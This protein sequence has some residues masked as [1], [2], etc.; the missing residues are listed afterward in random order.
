[1]T[2][3][4]SLIRQSLL[5]CAILQVGVLCGQALGQS[6]TL[7]ELTF[8]N[9]GAP[10][11]QAAFID[12]VLYLHSFEYEPARAAFQRAQEIDPSFALAYWGEAM[13]HHHSLWDRQ[14]PDL[15]E[16]ALQKFGASP[17][18]RAQKTPT[19]RERGFMTS[20]ETVFGLTEASA[21]KSKLERDVLYRDRMRRMY[22]DYPD[23]HEVA[24]FYGLSILGVA[25]ANREY[26]PYMRAAAVLL[27]IWDDNK[28]HP[29]AAHYLI[30]SLDDPVHAILALPMADA[31]IK[32]A[33]DA[34]HAQHMTSHIY[35]AL[36]HWDDVVAANLRGFNVESAKTTYTEVMSK[37][38]RHYTYWLAYGRL[39]QGRWD[40]AEELLAKMRDRL[41]NGA[42]GAERAYY[43]AIIARYMFDTEDWNVFEKWAAPSSVDIPTAHYDFARAFAAARLGK[44][45]AARAFAA[46]IEP[47]G[48]GNPEIFLSEDEVRILRLEVDAIVALAEGQNESAVSLMNEAVA[49]S[50]E[51]PF[52][53]GPPRLSKPTNELLGDV[54]AEVGDNEQAAQAYRDELDQS[55]RR[56]NSLLGLARAAAGLGEL[57]SSK[58]AYQQLRDIW[59]DADEALSWVDEARASASAS[60]QPSERP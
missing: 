52:R 55:V 22:E 25:S 10:E 40:D 44:V 48:E 32:I 45:E 13:T 39:Q 38:E 11:A 20:V 19:E 36:G 60:L 8:P 24:A 54:L 21:G 58:D 43:G 17:Q 28:L 15:G 51:L 53:Y 16:A 33:P 27:P 6:P 26:A 1:M 57:E 50:R 31:Y 37:E 41:D 12:G 35:T 5:L 30:H 9:S 34:A 23:D 47:G 46:S 56:T 18:E 14:R 29:G 42:T 2:K 3:S 7:G 4:T 59:H 49:M